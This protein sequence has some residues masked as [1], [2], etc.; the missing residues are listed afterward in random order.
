MTFT[1]DF[2]HQPVIAAGVLLRRH[3]ASGDRWLLLKSTKH[4]EWGFPKGHQDPGETALQTALREC[5]EET[6][7]SLLAIDGDP[8]ELNYRLPNGSPKRVIYFPAITAADVVVL[9][10]EHSAWRWAP[11][12]EVR[13]RLMLHANLVRLFDAH[14]RALGAI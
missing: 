4:G 2:P 5:V 6:G 10:D 13:E 1:V 7:V 8:L 12:N 11:A 9:S 3:T 14:V